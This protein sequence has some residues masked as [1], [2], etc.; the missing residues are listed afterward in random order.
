MR[1]LLV[2]DDIH[3]GDA[4]RTGL[5]QQGFV[6]DWLTDGASA[7]QA[8][9][10]E[11]FDLILLDLGLPKLS[12]L[13]FLK[14]FRAVGNTIP[15]MVLTARDAIEDKVRGLD[16]GADD[17][18]PK[19]F[20]LFELGA[21]V[22]A[23]IRR[24]QGRAN[25]HIFYR[26]LKLNPVAHEVMMDDK[27]VNLPRREFALLQTLLEHA[28]EVLSRDRLSQALY[29]WDEEIDSNAVEVHIHNLRKKL[30]ANY[31]RTIRGVGYILE[32]EENRSS[33]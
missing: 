15:V 12:G 3:L 5:V 2:E 23:L 4:V 33:S 20:D 8:V 27:L 14:N 7:W 29:G 25:A 21:R 26:N 22:R 1:L 9:K 32:K 16:S 18:L 6:V 28:G 31:I 30:N 13:A 10:F 24:S 11:T 17:Y 19:P